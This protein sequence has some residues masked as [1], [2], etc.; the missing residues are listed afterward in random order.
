[1]RFNGGEEKKETKTGDKGERKPRR[2]SKAGGGGTDRAKEGNAA[3]DRHEGEAG[4]RSSVRRGNPADGE[5]ARGALG[6]GADPRLTHRLVQTVGLEGER[7]RRQR[8]QVRVV[9]VGAFR[10]VQEDHR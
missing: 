1:M 10:V 3:R 2:R 5:G 7:I 9:R 6:F 4:N 8:P